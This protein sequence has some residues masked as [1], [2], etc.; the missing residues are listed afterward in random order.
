MSPGRAQKTGTER[1]KAVLPCRECVR[2]LEQF[3][4]AVR[5]VLTLNETHFL[6]VIDGDPDPHRFDILIHIANERKQ[7]AKYAYLQHQESH[8]QPEAP[9]NEAH[10][11]R[12]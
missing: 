12:T 7:E 1:R 6:A 11:D 10:P 3:G 2:L 8:D 4:D 9:R 5:D